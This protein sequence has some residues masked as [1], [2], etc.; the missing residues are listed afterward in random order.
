ML[1]R[2]FLVRIRREYHQNPKRLFIGS[3]V[4]TIVFSLIG[5]IADILLPFSGWGN[6][7]RSFILLP[8]SLSMFIFGYAISLFTHYSKLNNDSAWVPYRLRMSPSWR[9]RI[10]AI[11]AALMFVLIYANGF[12]VGYT[13]TS[14][15]FVAIGIGLFAFMR[16]T[17]EEA[18]REK[19]NIPDARD[20]KYN[21][22]MEN[23]AN[24][25][26]KKEE[27]KKLKRQT[28]LDKLT[29]RK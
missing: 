19:F 20:I 13:P 14:S 7:V 24:E 8:T 5:I 6:I 18:A 2:K 25:R 3:L 1:F 28:R 23:L 29:G 21:T 11:I 12:R 16:T 17:R 22:Q 10:S 26:A 9:R 27:A 15:M 4:S